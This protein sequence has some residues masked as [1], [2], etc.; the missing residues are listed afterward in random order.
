MCVWWKNLWNWSLHVKKKKK[1]NSPTSYFHVL[2]T[3]LADCLIQSVSVQKDFCWFSVSQVGWKWR[4]LAG[5]FRVIT[6]Y[7]GS[8]WEC[9]RLLKPTA[10]GNPAITSAGVK[11]LIHF[12]GFQT[13]LLIEEPDLSCSLPASRNQTVQARWYQAIVISSNFPFFSGQWKLEINEIAQNQLGNTH[14]K[15]L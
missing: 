1:Q 7:W 15:G 5:L 13:C 2:H 12:M 6:G 9:P 14:W 3:I 11:T 10:C 4:T 8:I